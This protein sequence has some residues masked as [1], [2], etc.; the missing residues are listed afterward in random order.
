VIAPYLG[1]LSDK[2]SISRPIYEAWA[3][4]EAEHKRQAERS[5]TWRSFAP[6]LAPRPSMKEHEGR[7]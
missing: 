3:Y 1:R 6:R 5:A 4:Y 2:A 7:G